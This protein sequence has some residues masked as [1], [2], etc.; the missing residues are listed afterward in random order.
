MTVEIEAVEGGWRRALRAARNT[1]WRGDTGAEPSEK[2]KWDLV[3]SQHSPL[4]CVEF[5]IHISGIKYWIANHLTRHKFGVEWFQ[6][7]LRP[8]RVGE[9]DRDASGQGDIVNLDCLINAQ[10]LINMAQFRLCR[11]AHQETRAVVFAIKDALYDVDDV[12]ADAL[13]PR[14]EYLK[15]C[16]E[17]VPCK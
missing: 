9:Y 8:D 15:S 1:V 7:S 14:C 2:F 16:P 13:R 5:Y 3:K 6:S 17:T 11:K 10:A 12:V 4:R